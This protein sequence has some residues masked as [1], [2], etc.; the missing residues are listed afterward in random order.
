M[1]NDPQTA[2]DETV[3]ITIGYVNYSEEGN[4]THTFYFG[5]VPD[6]Q[7]MKDRML[8]MI[9]ALYSYIR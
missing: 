7:K 6:Q 1:A 8:E 2:N 9:D 3:T 4:L 5:K